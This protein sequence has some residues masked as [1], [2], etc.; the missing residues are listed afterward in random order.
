VVKRSKG[1][2]AGI[3]NRSHNC[4][5]QVRALK[6]ARAAIWLTTVDPERGSACVLLPW[7]SKARPSVGNTHPHALHGI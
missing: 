2:P 6:L 3:V 4:E 1:V 7:T 5:L